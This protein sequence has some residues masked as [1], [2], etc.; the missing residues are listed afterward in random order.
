MLRRVL[1]LHVGDCQPKVFSQRR[2]LTTGAHNET[3]LIRNMAL[4]AHIGAF[5]KVEPTRINVKKVQI[6][7]K[8]HSQNPYCTSQRTW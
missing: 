4:V 2:F 1:W 7:E 3:S 8:R 5:V 6:L